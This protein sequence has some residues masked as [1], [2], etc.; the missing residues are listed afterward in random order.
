MKKL[1]KNKGIL[2][3]ITGLSGSGKTTIA[4][5]IKPE[6]A[7]FY[8]PTILISGDNLRT[9]F[10]LKKYSKNARYK[11]AL[12]FSTLCEFITN[13]KINV[14]FAVV[15]LFDKLHQQNRTNIQ[16]YVEI[17]VRSDLSKIIKIG[18]KRIYKKHNK[19]IVGKDI[20]AEMPKHPDIILD[21]K[22]NRSTNKLS[23][24]LLKKIKKIVKN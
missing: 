16:N 9:I 19:N 6:I 8:G 3:W 22:F 4:K 11:N 20:L 12:M 24:Q 10:N 21:N 2:F 5:K 1:K 23:I 17:Y 13:Q 15:G 14:I 7:K 18:K